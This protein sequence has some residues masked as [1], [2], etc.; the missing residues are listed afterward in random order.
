M[1]KKMPHKRRNG[2]PRSSPGRLSH[3]G[4]PVF[5]SF[6]RC[7]LMAGY[8]FA[9]GVPGVPGMFPPGPAAARDPVT[10]VAM[11]DSLTEGYRLPAAAAWP[12]LVEKRLRDEG[13]SVRMINGGV[14]GE[15]SAG[16]RRRVNW[17]LRMKPD[18]VILCTGAND[19]LRGLDPGEMRRNIRDIISR[20]QKQ[21]ITVILA[22]MK[23]LRNMGP[24]Y[25]DAFESVYPA[26]AREFSIP[27]LPFLL[28]GVAGNPALHLPD[29]IHPNREGHRR[30]A[31]LVY[32]L[33]RR[34]TGKYGF[35]ES[36]AQPGSPQ[37]GS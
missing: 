2:C 29:G 35:P 37:P 13:V 12:A 30:V 7:L 24:E 3:A 26:L 10:I 19:G 14:S 33:L 20:F 16:A 23:M 31:A 9:T 8:L 36:A 1:K 25:L 15:T 27:F 28:E 6:W 21:N 22:G 5:A 17:M 32:P 18:I 4:Y 11:G 34:E